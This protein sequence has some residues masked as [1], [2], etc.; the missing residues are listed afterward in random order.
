MHKKISRF[1]FGFVSLLLVVS[2]VQAQYLVSSKAGFINRVEG[3]ATIKSQDNSLEAA[4][5]ASLGAQMKE[6]DLLVTEAN[7]HAEILLSPGSYLRMN[8]KSEI[9]AVRTDFENTRFDVVA[10]AVIVEISDIDKKVPIEIGTPRTVVTINKAGIYRFDVIG[11]DVSVSVR[12]GEAYLGT[13]EQFFARTATKIGNNRA[14]RFVGD[15]APQTAKLSEKVYDLF[16]EWS[17]LRAETLMAA[18]YSVLRRTRSRDALSAGWVYDPFLNSYTFIPRRGF[19]LSAY[20]FGFYNQ[21]SNCDLCWGFNP[22][23]YGGYYGGGYYGGSAAG[24]GSQPGVAPRVTSNDRT[25]RG[26]ETSR[27]DVPSRRVEP[28]T[29]PSFGGD[30]SRSSSSSYSDASFGGRGG[31]YDRSVSSPGY[32][33]PSVS[34]PAPSRAEPSSN[35]GGRGGDTSRSTG[36]GN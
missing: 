15:G 5:K 4:G 19:L 13:R 36:R 33:S 34:S 26:G 11:K 14:Y 17:Y 8:E 9:A 10:G 23:Y 6:G 1:G 29:R 30:S 7:S 35:V 32:S 28:Y 3:K 16:D 27:T 25:V 12:R 20:G 22:Y 2:A 31:G 24:S 21:Y 18:N